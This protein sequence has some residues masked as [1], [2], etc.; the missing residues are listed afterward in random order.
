MAPSISLLLLFA[1]P[2]LALYESSGPVPL[3]NPRTFDAKIRKSNHSSIVEFFAPWC[4]PFVFICA[5]CLIFRCGHCKN[6][7]PAYT[8]AAEH[9]AGIFTFAAVDCDDQQNRGLCQEFDI[10]GFPTLK[11][12]KSYMGKVDATGTFLLLRIIRI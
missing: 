8:K 9:M 12:M 3:L 2:V 6:L 7:A 11:F 1:I 10:Q 4:P 5:F